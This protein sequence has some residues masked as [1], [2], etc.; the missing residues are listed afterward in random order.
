[1]ATESGLIISD[2][3]GRGVF[4]LVA[5]SVAPTDP[6]TNAIYLDDGTNTASTSP[7]WR[8]WNGSSWDDLGALSGSGITASSTDTL[9]NK[10]IDADGTGNA[11]TNIGSSEVKAELI[12]GLTADASPDGAA[13]YVMTY[14]DSAT[15]LKKVLL[16][17]LPGGGGGGAPTDA[18]YIVQTANGSLS[19]EQALGAL[20]TG[21]VKNTTTTGVLSIASAGTDYSSPSSTDTLT[22]KTF[23]ANG[24]GNSLS[25]VDVVDLADGTDGELITWDASGNPATVSVGTSG[26]VLTSNGV[27]AAP[28]FQASAGGGSGAL[29][30]LV[31]ET[32]LVGTTTTITLSSISALYADLI[33][34]VKAR[35]D[36]N[37]PGNL[38]VT[39][40]ADTG[41][42]YAYNYS[43]VNTA[44]TEGHIANENQ[45]NIVIPNA[46]TGLNSD[47]NF[48]GNAEI[49]I[50]GYA[51]NGIT[52][53]GHW[54][55]NAFHTA[56][57]FLRS[58]GAF[59]WENVANAI[60]SI[61]INASSG[62]FV[63]GTTYA[64]YGRGTAS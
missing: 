40:N 20:A 63:A 46:V 29:V 57:N 42:N 27:G 6:E 21:I 23:D 4:R 54:S 13:D 32:A 41:S 47:A 30:E 56:A 7:G 24:T 28:T 35:K 36:I 15:A 60:S 59:A 33:L 18:T 44:A 62:D 8:Q 10:S 45:A 58:E 55:A 31:A 34:V 37:A 48:F 50:L 19:N 2:H 1:M 11:V 22:N 61:E 26:H 64:L 52:R 49:H 14:D 38:V 17:D 5:R 25:N 39:L 16:D 3:A 12:T 53:G 51:N 9:T 43:T